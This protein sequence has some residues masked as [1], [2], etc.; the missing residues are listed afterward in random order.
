MFTIDTFILVIAFMIALYYVRKN[1]IK[2]ELPFWI[3]YMIIT[4]SSYNIYI[5]P[6]QDFL[7]PIPRTYIFFK[8]IIASLSP[9]D[10]FISV[11]FIKV[12]WKMSRYRS[13]RNFL[14]ANNSLSI[15]LRR[16]F[17]LLAISY[18]GLIFYYLANQPIDFNAQV[19]T[20]R[21]VLGGVVFVYFTCKLLNNYKEPGEYIRL[22]SMI[23]TIDFLNIISQFISSLFL[24]DIAWQRGGH[25][26]VLFDQTEGQLFF[27]YLPFILMK[28]KIIPTRIK[29]MAIIVVCLNI[30]N[31]P[32]TIYFY[33]GL[34]VIISIAFGVLRGRIPKRLTII[35]AGALFVIILFFSAFATGT[36]NS[37][38]SRL[39][40]VTSLFTVFEKNPINIFFGI[41]D[42]GLFPRQTMS[43]DGGEI[44]AVDLEGVEE[45]GLQGAVQ[46]RYLMFLKTSGVIG[47]LYALIVFARLLIRSFRFI[48]VSWLTFF[49][50]I[51]W[52]LYISGIMA[53]FRSDPQCAIFTCTQYIIFVFLYRICKYKN[54]LSPKIRNRIP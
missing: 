10:I 6:V 14:F 4:F 12:V 1:A 34:A 8:K 2:R 26:V 20:T 30:Y 49:F 9:F 25:N 43:E 27:T 37:K 11:M 32:K 51:C 41:G 33:S 18:L 35:G 5:K 44:R 42:G 28:N 29:W 39:G 3:I 50:Y 46:T 24:G 13:E 36:S 22:I 47:L 54:T 21:G 48:K 23:M 45:S 40:Q 19:R 16:E 31:F 17:V 7:I 15:I 53:L 38:L 52:L